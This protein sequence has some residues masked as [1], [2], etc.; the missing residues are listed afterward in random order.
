M[1]SSI[2]G[3]MWGDSAS[4]VKKYGKH[5]L[6][7]TQNGW[8]ININD[9]DIFFQFLPDS[10]TDITIDKNVLDK[11][12]ATKMMYVTSSINDTFAEGIAIS[13][14]TL[15]EFYGKNRNG[16]LQVAFTDYSTP[17]IPT[18]NCDNATTNVPVLYLSQGDEI[19]V[20]MIGNC[21][22]FQGTYGADFLRFSEK[23][24]YESIGIDTTQVTDG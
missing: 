22:I 1:V 21:I 3:L 5:K 14:Y 8:K 24:M 16:Y 19:S 12:L 20:D 2:I 17:A 6:K 10:L 18:I 9:K 4:D 7:L 23:I 15:S 11:I 13:E